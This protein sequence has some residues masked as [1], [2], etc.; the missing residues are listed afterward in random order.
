MLDDSD[1]PQDTHHSN[2]NQLQADVQPLHGGIAQELASLVQVQTL[3]A[4]L[5]KPRTT[6]KVTEGRLV[7]ASPLSVRG[8]TGVVRM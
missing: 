3:S 6:K 5:L 7:G 2:T 1:H 4:L 8:H